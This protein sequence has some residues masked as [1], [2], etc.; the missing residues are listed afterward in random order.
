MTDLR[1][2]E[3]AD[4]FVNATF[5]IYAGGFVLDWTHYMAIGWPTAS[6]GDKFNLIVWGFLW[7]I[8]WPFQ[9]LMAGW[10]WLIG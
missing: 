9:V 4:Q 7:S 5:L 2:E 3:L 6:A 1:R 8:F 10:Q